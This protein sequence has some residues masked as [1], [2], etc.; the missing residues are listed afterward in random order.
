MKEA[1]PGIKLSVIDITS[2]ITSIVKVFVSIGIIE[3]L[4]RATV[5]VIV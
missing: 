3:K 1:L 4:A 2:Q 5:R